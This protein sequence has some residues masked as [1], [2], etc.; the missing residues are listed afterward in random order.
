[1]LLRLSFA[2]DAVEA[3]A[4]SGVD[5]DDDESDKVRSSAKDCDL[6]SRTKN[7]EGTAA[8]ELFRCPLSIS[9]SEL[10]LR[11]PHITLIVILFVFLDPVLV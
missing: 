3:I 8:L 9:S 7:R 5:E 10:G 1:M 4:D 6:I 2:V 11:F